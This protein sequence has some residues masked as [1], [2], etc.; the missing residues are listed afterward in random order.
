MIKNYKNFLIFIPARYESS[1]FP[2][3]PLVKILGIEMIKRVYDNCN[4][5]AKNKTYVLTDN[6][7]IY[8]FCIKHKIKC[9]MTPKNCK[10]GTDRIIYI[11]K[12]LKTALYINVQGDEPL[13]EKKNLEKFIKTAKKDKG[14]ILI[15]KSKINK[16][17]FK[18]IN[19]PK[20]IV[21][22][23]NE[24]IYISRLGL[25][26]SKN[27]KNPSKMYGQ[28]NLYSFPYKIINNF[29]KYNKKNYIEEIED[30]EILRFLYEDHKVKVIELKSNNHAVDIPSDI[31]TVEKIM[32]KNRKY[33][34]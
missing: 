21:N 12:K 25:P 19:L 2:G 7:K 30:I 13:I 22:K 10:T 1:R 24:L 26:G 28:V 4:S 11:S 29:K 6:K 31:I 5:V 18:N 33:N 15:A 34:K 32:K 9:L 8:N 3:K 20:I 17:Q 27:G 23:N 14:N 16:K